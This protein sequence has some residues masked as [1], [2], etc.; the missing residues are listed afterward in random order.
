MKRKGRMYSIKSHLFFYAACFILPIILFLLASNAYAV[1]LIQK[2]VAASDH[3]TVELYA[4]QLDERL[5]NLHDYLIHL[6]MY[7]PAFLRFGTEKD[8]DFIQLYG[9][10]LQNKVSSELGIYSDVADGVFFYRP[11]EEIYSKKMLFVEETGVQEAIED[12]IRELAGRLRGDGDQVNAQWFSDEIGGNYYL[13]RIYCYKGICYGSW[14]NAERMLENLITV[15]I[16]DAEKVLVLDSG[17]RAL[18]QWEK[19]EKIQVEWP[20]VF[21]KDYVTEQGGEYLVIGVPILSGAYYLS[22]FIPVR[23]ILG[24]ARLFRYWIAGLLGISCLLLMLF[25]RFAQ[26][27][28][29]DPLASL[30][31]KLKVEAGALSVQLPA[32]ERIA[33]FSAVNGSFNSMVREIKN[34]KIQVYEE[35]LQTQAAEL[36]FLQIQTNPHFFINA[37]NLI[38]N[39]ARLN[40]LNEVK[41]FTRDL[42]RHFRYTLYGKS[43]VTVR[44]ELDFIGNYMQMQQKKDMGLSRVKLEIQIEEGLEK[45]VLPILV[46]QTFVENSMKYGETKE[47]ETDI[48]IR[49]SRCGREHIKLLIQDAG[50]GFG[51]EELDMLERCADEWGGRRHIGVANVKN[52]LKI[53]YGD[54]AAVCFFNRESG[55]AAVEI[56]LPFQIEE[57]RQE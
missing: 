29:A 9:Y 28:I 30:S 5:E 48:G 57:E 24:G 39:Y 26:R 14:C 31:E 37:M 51:R 17:Y 11:G 3:N 20:E 15:P 23:S 4:R 1:R 13:F 27:E 44:E 43:W 2:Q 54:Q 41:E 32:E 45:A 35:K 18:G 16:E 50:K 33:E 8:R 53:L 42:I 6:G 21:L 52:R 36:E 12:H 10:E 40:M 19:W 25:F 34:L 47:G 55:G 46:I 7:T 49:V 38:L 22:C 56:K